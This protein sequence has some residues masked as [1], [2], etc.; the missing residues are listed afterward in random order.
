MLVA[1][2]IFATATLLGWLGLIC[3]PIGIAL[4]IGSLDQ[5]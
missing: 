5:G 2:S 3:L 1:A 4:L